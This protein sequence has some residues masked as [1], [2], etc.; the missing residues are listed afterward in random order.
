MFNDTE[1]GGIKVLENIVR[2]IRNFEKG[3]KIDIRFSITDPVDSDKTTIIRELL[4]LDIDILS[5]SAGIYD[6][7]KSQIYPGSHAGQL[8]YYDLAKQ[9]FNSGPEINLAGNISR[10]DLLNNSYNVSYSIGR[11]LIANPRFV[12]DNSTHCNYRN[13]CHYYSRSRDH[14][15]C[16][17]SRDLS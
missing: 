9:F 11:N 12:I 7:D 3:I 16:P 4:N 14:I 5:F 13:K 17:I 2:G 1:I 15:E 6:I 8:P 10:I